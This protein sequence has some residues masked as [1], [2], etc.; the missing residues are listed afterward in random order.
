[1]LPAAAGWRERLRHAYNLADADA[2]GGAKK[3][4]FGTDRRGRP[5]PLGDIPPRE[6]LGLSDA[7]R[8]EILE[9]TADYIVAALANG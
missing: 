1:M 2:L 3:R 6:F 8:E 5:I 4:A 7:D 9:T